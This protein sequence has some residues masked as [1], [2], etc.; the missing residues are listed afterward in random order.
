MMFN[1]HIDMLKL[2]ENG[3]FWIFGLFLNKLSLVNLYQS[4]TFSVVFNPEKPILGLRIWN[5]DNPNPGIYKKSGFCKPYQD[6]FSYPELISTYWPYFIQFNCSPAPR[7]IYWILLTLLFSTGNVQLY[8]IYLHPTQ[9]GN[10]LRIIFDFLLFRISSNNG[11]QN[12]QENKLW[13][14]TNGKH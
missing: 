8:S 13:R 10:I 3:Q 9:N 1:I 14:R 5:R 11:R 4:S 2:Y 6:P 7:L 12:S